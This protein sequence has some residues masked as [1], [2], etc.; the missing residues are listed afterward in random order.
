MHF[1]DPFNRNAHF[2]LTGLL[3]KIVEKFEIVYII[4]I[5]NAYFMYV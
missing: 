2:L 3:T 1:N 4:Y 5:W